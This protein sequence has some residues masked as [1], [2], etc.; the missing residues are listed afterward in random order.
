MKKEEFKIDETEIDQ[1][2]KDFNTK[3]SREVRDRLNCIVIEQ[4]DRYYRD[5]ERE[6]QIRRRS[7]DR[8]FER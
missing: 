1:L 8:G 6:R 4:Q 7:R 3:P 5:K 2:I